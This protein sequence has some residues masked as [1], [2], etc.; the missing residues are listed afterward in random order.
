[1]N[2]LKSLIAVCIFLTVPACVSAETWIPYG[3]NDYF[4][5]YFDADSMN[6]SVAGLNNIRVWTKWSITQAGRAE[7]FSKNKKLKKNGAV[8]KT[9]WLI[10]CT[11]QEMY[12]E[13]NYVFDKK[14]QFLEGGALKPAQK[15]DVMPGTMVETLVSKSCDMF[16]KTSRQPEEQFV[17]APPAP[18]PPS[19]E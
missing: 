1:M 19:K 15:I 12:E 18:L 7:M 8:M 11:D 5:A 4:E 3:S 17:G 13:A 9:K 6:A 2:K 16:R 10:Y 14:G